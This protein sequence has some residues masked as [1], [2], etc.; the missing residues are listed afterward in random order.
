MTEPRGSIWLSNHRTRFRALLHMAEIRGLSDRCHL[1][2]KSA[3]ET[4]YLLQYTKPAAD[5]KT[6]VIVGVRCVKRQRRQ[7]E[8]SGIR[9]PEANNKPIIPALCHSLYALRPIQAGNMVQSVLRMLVQNR[10]QLTIYMSP[11]DAT[12]P[13]R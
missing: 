5:W 2:A 9:Q 13:C 7:F 10:V 12:Y 4:E 1:Q 11:G 8:V 6:D 3:G